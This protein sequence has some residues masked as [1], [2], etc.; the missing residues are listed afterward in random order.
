MPCNLQESL[1][2]TNSGRPAVGWV[3][4]QPAAKNGQMVNLLGWNL[5]WTSWGGEKHQ[6]STKTV[7]LFTKKHER[8]GH[9]WDEIDPES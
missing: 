6:Q 3:T 8:A 9:F 5:K 2:S 1:E 7:G 4:G